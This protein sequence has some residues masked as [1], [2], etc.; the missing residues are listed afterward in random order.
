MKGE[1]VYILVD[2]LINLAIGSLGP[3]IPPQDTVLALEGIL[4]LKKQH[5]IFT[6]DWFHGR[7]I[8]QRLF[9]AVLR[10]SSIRFISNRLC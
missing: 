4:E 9:L 1:N 5:D 7:D 10:V 6:V 2:C 3:N 8:W